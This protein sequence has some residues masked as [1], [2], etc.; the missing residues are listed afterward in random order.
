MWRTEPQWPDAT[1]QRFSMAAGKVRCER[2]AA[3][4]LPLIQL[5]MWAARADALS[6]PAEIAADHQRCFATCDFDGYRLRF[7][8]RWFA[9]MPDEIAQIILAHETAHAY[10]LATLESPLLGLDGCGANEEELAFAFRTEEIEVDQILMTWGFDHNDLWDW[11]RTSDDARRLA[12]EER[13]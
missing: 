4:Y 7:Q 3:A 11:L 12:E 1:C 2:P 8:A 5:D 6:S 10:L 9:I 13:V